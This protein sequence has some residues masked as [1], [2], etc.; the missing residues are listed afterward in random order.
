MS[1]INWWR[2]LGTVACVLVTLGCVS[3]CQWNL[4]NIKQ[5]SQ[6]S[7][8]RDVKKDE[9]KRVFRFYLAATNEFNYNE[10]KHGNQYDLIWQQA[11]ANEP[12][13]GFKV[14]D[15]ERLEQEL[16]AAKEAGRSYEDLESTTDALL[17]ILHDIVSDIKALDSYYKTKQYE[18]DNYALS[19][20]TLA[21]L[22]ALIEVFEP[23]YE[24]LNEAVTA[25]HKKERNKDIESM[26]SN[27]QVNGAY[28]V[29]MMG[30]YSDIVSHIIDQGPNS[31]VQW[32]KVQKEAANAIVPKFTSV[33]V[34]NRIDQAKN[35]DAAIDAFVAEQSA[36][37]HHEVI[38]Q[39]NELVRTPMNFKLL[40]KTQDAYIPEGV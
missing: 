5:Y 7:S 12:L 20:A 39:Y 40:D 1:G 8:A 18:N 6:D 3:G 27:G 38:S 15:Y 19:Q 25:A 28:M 11:G 14:Q 32:V 2:R 34:Q 29:E 23:K 35:L 31:D 22:S 30:Y 37:T 4:D 33:E 17:P 36:E 16:V 10:V 24:A 26:R 21:K 13:T 9:T